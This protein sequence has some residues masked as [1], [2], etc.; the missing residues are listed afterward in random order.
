MKTKHLFAG[1]IIGIII[2]TVIL[3]VANNKNE[4]VYTPRGNFKNSNY[5]AE[6]MIKWMHER[7]ADLITGEID[8]ADVE[9]ARV[10]VEQMMSN[11]GTSAFN[12]SWDELGPDNQGGRTRAL[13]IDKDN[14]D[15]MY[16]GGVSG[17]LWKSTTG[18][19]SW[20]KISDTYDCN[21][22]V[23]ICQAANGDIYF[24]TGES[25]SSNDGTD[26]NT[27]V[28]GQGIWK[29]TD[30][31]NF[32]R[33][34]STWSS[35]DGVIQATF[36]YISDLAAH[37]TNEYKI[38][39]GTNR[40]LLVTEDG[41][42]TWT[43]VLV[44]GQVEINSPVT[45]IK[46]SPSGFVIASIGNCCFISNSGGVGT[47]IKKSDDA[48]ENI[49]PAQYPDWKF[50][51]LEF[52]IAPSNENY[53]Y[54]LVAA[55][56]LISPMPNQQYRRGVFANIYIS[57]NKGV[58]WTKLFSESPG[59]NFD[60]FGGNNQGKYDNVIA[61]YPNNPD[62][63]L[64]GGV[65]LWKWEVGST[66]ERISLW[67]E[68]AYPYFVHAD[69]H[70]IVFHPKYDGVNNKTIFFAN[71]GGVFRSLNGGSTFQEINKLYITTQFYSVGFSGDGRV[72]GGTQ[73]NGTKYIDFLGNTAKTAVE[74]TGGDGGGCAF[75][76]LNP[77]AIFT[78]IYHGQ[79]RRSNERGDNIDDNVYNNY[80]KNSQ[81][82]GTDYEPFV[83]QIALWESFYDPLSCDSI[84]FE[85]DRNYAVGEVLTIPSAIFQRPIYHTITASDVAPY[86]S[87]YEEDILKVQDT[88]QAVLAVG[89]NG[90]VWI[91]R[92][93]FDFSNPPEW[94]P[95]IDTGVVPCNMITALA[96]AKDGDYLYA[97]DH[98]NQTGTSRIFRLSNIM[99]SRTDDQMN[100]YDLNYSTQLTIHTQQI[101]TFTYQ[102]V[103]DIAVDPSNP[104]NVIV[105]LGNYNHSDY[106]FFSSNA[107]TT[108]ST[109]TSS[110]FISIQGNLPEMP[111]Y[112]AV[113][114]WDDSRKVI[115]GT[116]FGVFAT[117]D[118]TS[119]SVTWT[120]ENNGL[121]IVPVYMIR[122]QTTSNFWASGNSGVTNHGILYA[123]THGRGL[124]KC[125]TLRSPLAVEEVNDN[126]NISI[127][128][129]ILVYPN[130]AS[131]IANVQFKL[132]K[133]SDVDIKVYDLNG[134][135]VIK[136]F[137]S[138]L[139]SGE[140]TYPITTR[141][142][143]KG[144]YIICLTSEG[145]KSTGKF[146]VH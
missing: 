40:G 94:W 90:N 126:T 83:T 142:L 6:G 104:N 26:L 78:T 92:H 61:V 7:K 136:D 107:A 85:A 29:S 39:A 17:G 80:L 44:S 53:I 32:T 129:N 109:S 97:A 132:H 140:H 145:N 20:A 28:S 70:A 123:A 113:I 47:F 46:I 9:K 146:I 111:V 34:E 14:N 99:T 35:T 3:T 130:P 82:I 11:K 103:T 120:A 13:L 81:Q 2:L 125:E 37:P 117:D 110:N 23:S 12:L 36:C 73:D 76:M 98:N 105:T 57:H 88:Y 51:R 75:S 60:I 33:L 48:T 55:D 25:F 134:R 66:V 108:N 16:A 27:G 121:G 65:D 42:A 114:N 127:L 1:S 116:D 41:G 49:W 86:D 24:G 67:Q 106:V 68:F 8:I 89:L 45:D 59:E 135:L 4:G 64:I 31:T 139:C 54:C 21:T 144:T 56:T 118:I 79:L 62:K 128:G 30:G 100:A 69:Q 131:N 115:I 102:L 96:W 15:I 22:I 93:P 138:K 84:E 38:Y 52:A 43:N 122:Q 141:Y 72:A 91:T 119:T 50:S 5:S 19:L 18:G 112:T 77:D 58:T 87:L 71:D 10:Q 63:I 95:I 124:F 143:D 133:A 137:K 74:I 101:G